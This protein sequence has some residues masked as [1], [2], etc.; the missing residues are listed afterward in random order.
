MSTPQRSETPFVETE[1]LLAVMN[2]D[3][4]RLQHLL[5]GMT[6][7]ELAELSRQVATLHDA[8]QRARFR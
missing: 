8:V 1:A 7:R 3:D 4:V 6:R 2:E 5:D